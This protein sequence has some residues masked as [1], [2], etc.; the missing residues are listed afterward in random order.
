MTDAAPRRVKIDPLRGG[1]ML[2]LFVFGQILFT[3][4]LYVVIQGKDNL[5]GIG[6]LLHTDVEE[7]G[8]DR[9]RVIVGH[10]MRG[11]D[12]DKVA[13]VYFLS[14]F[15]IEAILLNDFFNKILCHG[16]SFMV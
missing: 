16:P 10:H 2:Y 1:K 3:G 7:F 15:Q 8:H 11:P 4:V 5:T 9:R 13:A 14:L 12:G 6:H